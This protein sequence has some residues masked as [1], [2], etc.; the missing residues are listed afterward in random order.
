MITDFIISKADKESE[1]F[2]GV[3]KPILGTLKGLVPKLFVNESSYPVHHDHIQFI[4]NS[5]KW[6]ESSWPNPEFP[7]DHVPDGPDRVKYDIL[8]KRCATAAWI[9]SLLDHEKF[10]RGPNLRN[11]LYLPTPPE[12]EVR[13]SWTM[14]A[15]VLIAQN[16]GE[17]GLKGCTH[18]T[19]GLEVMGIFNGSTD[20]MED[21][22]VAPTVQPPFEGG[23]VESVDEVFTTG[24]N[25]QL[26][27]S[28]DIPSSAKFSHSLSDK[29]FITAQFSLSFA[30]FAFF[31]V[32]L[33]VIG[34]AVY[35]RG[36]RR[37]SP[38][39]FLP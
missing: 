4:A 33:V 29:N 2:Y 18:H 35:R 8:S 12:I 19:N 38:K 32:L 17:P 25:T 30:N 28:S 21:A 15:A 5:R 14:G 1:S 31:A 9:S 39:I 34:A 13:A 10:Y 22:F 37:S 20:S 6:C 26:I 36:L 23:S 3:G 24:T 27:E 7:D 16:T 11:N